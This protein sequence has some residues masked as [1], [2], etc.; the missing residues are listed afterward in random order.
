MIM[1]KGTRMCS[2][3]FNNLNVI[4]LSIRK[5]YLMLVS[6]V[7]YREHVK[8]RSRPVTTL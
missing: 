5:H 6:R 7:F 2:L 4:R 1:S 8:T 3:A